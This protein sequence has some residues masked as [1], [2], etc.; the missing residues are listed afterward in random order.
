M[1]QFKLQFLKPFSPYCL[2]GRP[3][4]L[5]LLV[6]PAAVAYVA[7]VRYDGGTNLT[8]NNVRVTQ[9]YME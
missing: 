3:T 7:R 4:A 9:K 8:E 1:C 2:R 5:V 6:R